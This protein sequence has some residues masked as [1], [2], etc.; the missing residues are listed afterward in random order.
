MYGDPLYRAF[1]EGYSPYNTELEKK[2]GEAVMKYLKRIDKVAYIRFASV[3][4]SFQDAQAFREELN[5]ILKT[6]KK[7]KNLHKTKKNYN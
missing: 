6:K 7:N 5:K 4:E 1:V 2:I 3:Y